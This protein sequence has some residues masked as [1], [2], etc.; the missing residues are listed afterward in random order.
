MDCRNPHVR[1]KKNYGPSDPERIGCV[2]GKTNRRLKKKKIGNKVVPTS[3]YGRD[4]TV[5]GG[6]LEEEEEEVVSI[7]R[8]LI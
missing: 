4:V 6:K 2:F 5:V 7:V 8:H 3:H 1:P